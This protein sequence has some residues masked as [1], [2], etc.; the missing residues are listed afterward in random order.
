MTPAFQIPRSF[1]AYS[2]VVSESCNSCFG[3]PTNKVKKKV[4]YKEECKARKNDEILKFKT[5]ICLRAGKLKYVKFKPALRF[6]CIL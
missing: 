5:C 3:K 1:W 2:D 4:E 6:N